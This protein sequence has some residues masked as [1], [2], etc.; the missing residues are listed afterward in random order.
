MLS[1]EYSST[2]QT[3]RRVAQ[4]M[5]DPAIADRLKVLAESYER[6]AEIASHPESA[7]D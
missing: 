6:R 1:K 3:L 7:K 5:S 4:S 2:A